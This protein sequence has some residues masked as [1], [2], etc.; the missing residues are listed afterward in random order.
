MAPAK[1]SPRAQS[2]LVWAVYA[3]GLAPAL[4][5]FWL[6]ASNQLGADPVKTFER[7]LGLWTIRFL[8]LTLAITPLRD[9][10]L[11]NGLRYRRALGLLAFYYAALH[12][13][14][15][16]VLDQTMVLS[17]IV[18]DV[19]KRPFITFGMIALTLLVPLAVTSNNASIRR[20]GSRWSSL[21][22]LVYPVAALG[23]LHYSMAVKVLGAEQYIHIGLLVLLLAYR[24]ARPRLMEAKRQKR[25]AAA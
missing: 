12:F 22:R 14:T 10:G 8:I 1:L 25:R 23:A 15:Y 13:L 7:F 21:H 3:V 4:W 6:G 9:L 17:A 24:I 19:V 18:A 2:A 20:L 16:A 11:F 5:T